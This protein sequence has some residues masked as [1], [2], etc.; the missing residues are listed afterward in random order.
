MGATTRENHAEV[1]L[2]A[3]DLFGAIY[4]KKRKKMGVTTRE[5]HAEVFLERVN[6]FGKN[7]KKWERPHG[8]TMQDF[9]FKGSNFLGH[10]LQLPGLGVIVSATGGAQTP[11]HI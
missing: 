9:F 5:N 11:H 1:C 3:V 8:K 6:L 10:I 7:A 4:Q 2:E